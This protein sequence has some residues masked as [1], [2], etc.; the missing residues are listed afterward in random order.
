MP[1]QHFNFFK[2]VMLDNLNQKKKNLKNKI[3]LNPK[4]QKN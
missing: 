3:K 1:R 2:K 4:T